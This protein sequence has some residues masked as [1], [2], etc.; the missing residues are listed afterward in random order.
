MRRTQVPSG[1][2]GNRPVSSSQSA[3]SFRL[4]QLRP[5][6]VAVGS[7]AL[8][9]AARH[10]SEIDVD[11]ERLGTD[12][13]PGRDHAM[14]LLGVD[15]LGRSDLDVLLVSYG[16]MARICQTA[17]DE[18]KDEGISIGLF[19]PI[20]LFPYPEEE[21]R[22]EALKKN[23]GSVLTIEMSCGQMVEDVERAVMGR[24]P[25]SWYGK[26]GGEVPSPDRVEEL[27]ES[28][29]ALGDSPALQSMELKA[30]DA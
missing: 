7:A 2:P 9:L 24:L 18:L 25:V 4:I 12:E 22:K 15:I 6:S 3:P 26:C 14:A 27:F 5:S 1:T 10:G 20:T 29:A 23:I 28:E 19:R 17:I 13:R 8:D 11:R 16:T 30:F 21:L